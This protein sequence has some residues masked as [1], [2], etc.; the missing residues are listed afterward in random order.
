MFSN[1]AGSK[2]KTLLNSHDCKYAWSISRFFLSLKYN[3]TND[4]YLAKK[5]QPRLI[6][7]REHTV[8]KT[9]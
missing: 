8:R 9:K 4:R 5:F 7:G 2:T 3:F 1:F 6:V